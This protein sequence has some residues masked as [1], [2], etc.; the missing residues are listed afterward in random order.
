MSK[1]MLKA[2]VFGL[3]ITEGTKLHAHIDY[4]QSLCVELQKF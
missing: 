1:A 3:R 2:K 4:F